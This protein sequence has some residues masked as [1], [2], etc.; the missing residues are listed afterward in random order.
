MGG[1]SYQEGDKLLC[2]DIKRDLWTSKL[3]V[4]D[5][6]F[7]IVHREEGILIKRIVEHDLENGK[8]TCHS[9]NPMYEDFT[10]QLNDV[11]KLYNVIKIV[12]RVV[13]R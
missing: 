4:N 2:R 10:L 3:R 8:I 5:W 6:D 1:S 13:R 11:A 9:L 12:D 7:V